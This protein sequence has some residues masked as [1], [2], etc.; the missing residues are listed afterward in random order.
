[1]SMNSKN[2]YL[3]SKQLEKKL[4]PVLQFILAEEDELVGVVCPDCS[5]PCQ[6]GDEVVAPASVLHHAGCAS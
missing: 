4:G 6:V 3:T 1:M 5:K 2:R